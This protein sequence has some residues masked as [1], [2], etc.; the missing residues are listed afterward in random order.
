MKGTRPSRAPASHRRPSPPRRGARPAEMPQASIP[1]ARARQHAGP[2]A[3]RRHR[4]AVTQRHRPAPRDGVERPGSA[5]PDMAAPPPTPPPT[6]PLPGRTARSGRGRAATGPAA[7]AAD[8][9]D[10]D[11][12]PSA[13]MPRSATVGGGRARAGAGGTSDSPHRVTGSAPLGSTGP[14][15]PFHPIVGKPRKRHQPTGETLTYHFVNSP[16]DGPLSVPPTRPAPP[17]GTKPMFA[18]P[19]QPSACRPI[20]GLPYSQHARRSIAGGCVRTGPRIVEGA[21]RTLVREHQPVKLID[22]P[23]RTRDGRLYSPIREWVENCRSPI[24]SGS[25]A[26]QGRWRAP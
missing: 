18:Y 2:A 13:R 20:A 9:P 8:P 17:E 19:L 1:A 23:P 26:D 24:S 4:R 5:P 22:G 11:A 10:A 7:G 16:G 14:H 15:S 21:G 25:M 3:A 6:T 12:A